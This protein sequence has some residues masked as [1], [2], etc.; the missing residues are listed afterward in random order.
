MCLVSGGPAYIALAGGAGLGVTAAAT[1]GNVLVIHGVD[2]SRWDER[3]A[4]LQRIVSAGQVFGLLLAGGLAASHMRLAF[5]FAAVAL[6]IA[7]V[8]AMSSAP[9]S[10][11]QAGMARPLP[12]PLVGGEAGVPGPQHNAHHFH[13]GQLGEFLGAITRSLARFL[14][15]WVIAFTAMNGVAVLFPVVM[16]NQYAMPAILPAGAYAVGVAASLLLYRRVGVLTGRYGAWRVLTV[17]LGARLFLLACLAWFGLSHASWAGISVLITFS[18]IQMVWPI[19]AVSASALSVELVPAAR[20]ESVGLFN[21]ATA[22]ASSL[23]SAIGGVIFGLYGFSALSAVAFVAVG[24]G[25]WLSAVWFG[26][27]PHAV[28]SSAVASSPP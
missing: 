27:A 16:T 23:G 2:E 25:V 9:S 5:V 14:V 21:A 26:R 8:L 3:V 11:V 17:G 7:A 10:S 4:D 13:L 12:Q 20:G 18:I 19:L 1:A 24:V 22:V 6:M 15:V 28:G